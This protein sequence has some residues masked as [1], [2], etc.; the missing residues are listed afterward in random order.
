MSS[1]TRIGPTREATT[2]NAL[3]PILF[4]KD[5]SVDIRSPSMAAV[6]ALKVCP[7]NS[8]LIAVTGQ[9]GLIKVLKTTILVKH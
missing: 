2:R 5:V 4:L 3:Y 8:K 1:V 6:R 7:Y 9:H